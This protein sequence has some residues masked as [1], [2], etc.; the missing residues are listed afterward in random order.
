MARPREFDEQLAV[1][2]AMQLFWRRG[3]QAASLNEL[4]DAMDLSRSSFYETWGTKR[5]ALIE[6]LNRYAQSGMAGLIEPLTRADAGRAQ[7]EQTFHGMVR[8]A[9]SDG[10]AKGCLVNNCLA[11]LAGQDAKLLQ[12]L[13]DIRKGLERLLARAIRKGQIDGTIDSTQSATTLARFLASTFSGLNL[14]ARAQPGKAVLNDIVRTA[15]RA[16]D[17]R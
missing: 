17:P 4:L 1:E 11:E 5:E 3:Y 14:T 8:H 2:K 7:I 15:L 6:A 13:Q 10:G 12:Q 9:L 16:L